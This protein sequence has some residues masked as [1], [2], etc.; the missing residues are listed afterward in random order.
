MKW[1]YTKLVAIIILGAVLA[2]FLYALIFKIE[3]EKLPAIHVP[4]M[5]AGGKI[6][7]LNDIKDIYS[8]L[9]NKEKMNKDEAMNLI[10]STTKE[11][12]FIEKTAKK[13]NIKPIALNDTKALNI[14]EEKL[15]ADKMS[16]ELYGW[17]IDKF[18]RLVIDPLE[19]KRGVADWYYKEN[20]L[21]IKQQLETIKKDLKSVNEIQSLPNYKY[22][23]FIEL[24]ALPPMMQISVLN[25]KPNTISDVIETFDGYQLIYLQSVMAE[26]N[27]F[28]V[29]VLTS[30][31]K[32]LTAWL[33]K[34]SSSIWLF[35]FVK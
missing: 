29:S 19:L 35:S 8:I 33:E 1:L 9:I 23:G 34:N 7:W 20:N 21:P 12:I 22:L 2:N 17:S 26:Q 14:K 16:N 4:A 27:L 6:I 3:L 10:V 28:E 5:I 15:N 24:K 13:L 32:T 11:Q 18:K 25:Q 31:K 30:P